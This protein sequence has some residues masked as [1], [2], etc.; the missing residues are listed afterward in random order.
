MFKVP[1]LV[2]RRFHYYVSSWLP[3]NFP[4]SARPLTVMIPLAAKDLDNAA[5]AVASLRRHLLH[6]V[7]EIVVAGE[8]DDTIRAF[9]AS[10]GV[11]Y[12]NENEV[13]PAE[14]LDL[15]DYFQ[16]KRIGGWVR[17][18][19]LKFMAFDYLE[20]DDILVF[21][22][23]TFLVH[24]LSFFAGDRQ[25]LFLAD[26]YWNMHHESTI[27]LLG[28]IPRHPRSFIAHFML[29]QRDLMADMA[30]AVQARCG[31]DMMDAIIAWLKSEHPTPP[32]PPLAEYELYGNYLYNFRKDRFVATYW[33]NKRIDPA[34]M[35]P[36]E[37]LQRKY[38]RFNSLSAHIR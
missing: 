17:Q 34:D 21:D 25:L 31:C 13:L 5:R 23:D 38:K 24:D 6:P 8:D 15:V 20:G 37:E 36:L 2:R 32:P 35:P 28:P 12:I 9:C 3:R 10:A 30:R 26:E 29:F 11:R 1:R 27:A 19:M 33:Y 7:R 14:V 18:Q 22:A 4:P 16:S